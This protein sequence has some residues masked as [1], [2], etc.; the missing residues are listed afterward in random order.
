VTTGSATSWNFTEGT[1]IAPGRTVLKRFTSLSELYETYL[2]WDDHRFAI[3]VAK[4]VMPQRI[5]DAAARQGIE[6]EWRALTRLQHPIVVR[7]FDA[8]RDGPHPHLLLEH[9]E[10]FTLQSV[11]HRQ[12]PL[13]LEQ[14]LPLALHIASALHYFASEGCIHLD[15]KPENIIMSAPPRLIDLSL[16][17]SLE[18][19]AKINYLVGTDSFM[20]PEQCLRGEGPPITPAADIFGLAATLHF[21]CTGGV[22]FPR[23]PREERYTLAD[24]FPQIED[25]PLPLPSSVPSALREVLVQALSRDPRDRPTAAEFAIQLQPLVAQLPHRFVMTKSGWMA[26]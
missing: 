26:R 25:D 8:V 1:E 15:V 3:M 5:G 10:G 9:L 18:E 14:L 11:V 13:P 6:R 7:A 19:A 2:V 4:L 23:P 17:H 16:V 24:R 22:P 20:A 21:A 12:G